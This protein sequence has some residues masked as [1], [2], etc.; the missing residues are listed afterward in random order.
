ML[1]TR[2]HNKKTPQQGFK[3]IDRLRV[4]GMAFAGIPHAFVFS[5]N[6][7]PIYYWVWLFFCCIL[8]PHVARWR[9][10]RSV[11]PRKA[12]RHNLMFD[13][14]VAGSLIPLIEF[15]LLPTVL[16]LTIVFGDSISSAARNLW[17]YSLPL[18]FSGIVSLG[19]IT[20]FEVKLDSSMTVIIACFPL[21]I[22][23]TLSVS[24]G[25]YQMIGY[26]RS[27]NAML[28]KLSMMD[29]LTNLYNKRYWEEAAEAEFKA[30]REDQ[31]SRVVMVI[32]CDKFK[33]INDT[34]GHL[35]GDKVLKYIGHILSDIQ[36]VSAVAARLG[37]DEFAVL[38]ETDLDHAHTVAADIRA[39]MKA[40]PE[41]QEAQEKIGCSV[42]I[43]LAKFAV[44]DQSFI[45]CFDRAD[46][47]LYKQK[48]S[49]RG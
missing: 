49:G 29:V 3:A 6:H 16:T 20:G 31:K 24:W 23:H 8:W 10:H 37:G 48:K 44:S 30:F 5:E 40:L 35:A 12:E 43:G 25:N 17:Y 32:D 2:Q 42:S 11:K 27:R 18:V 46:K 39:Q 4:T 14:F 21:L 19:L 26:I 33:Q 34:Y 38:M 28:N 22:V 45:D 7:A 13:S 36:G 1:N 9:T 47:D 15:N 41:C